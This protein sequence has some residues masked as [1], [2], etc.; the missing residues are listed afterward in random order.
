MT[1][2][3]PAP[4]LLPALA[5]C[6]ALSG[7]S[8][9]ARAEEPKLIGSFRD[10][11]AFMLEEPGGRVCWMASRP[12]KQEGDFAKRGDVFALITHR[13]HE[14]SL[15][16]VSVIAGYAFAPDTTVTLE[17][18]R[19]TWKLFVDGETAWAREETT[20]RAISQAIRQGTTMVVRGTSS[21]GT[22]T[23]DTYS[24]AGTGAAY[25]AMNKACS[26][27]GR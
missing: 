20:D 22:R 8:M 11:N 9:P 16:V 23:A 12:K 14:R 13:P 27:E 17:V 25:Q 18:G 26:V 3:R 2:T 4:A 1:R 15:D 24:L 19:Q 5:L 10:W 21:R 6:A 7:W